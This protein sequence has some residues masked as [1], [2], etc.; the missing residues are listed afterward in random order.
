MKLAPPADLA[1]DSG[2]QFPVSWSTR[3]WTALFLTLQ[4]LQIPLSMARPSSSRQVRLSFRL[5]NGS[6]LSSLRPNP[7]FYER[8]VGW[9]TNWTAPGASVTAYAAWLRRSRGRFS[10][11]LTDFLPEGRDQDLAPVGAN[12]A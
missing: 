11:L 1:L 12:T 5:G 9:P 4:A 3:T 7:L 10:K 2:G 8:L 6:L